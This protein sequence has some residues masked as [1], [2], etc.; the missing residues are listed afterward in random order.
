MDREI[1]LCLARTTVANSGTFKPGHAKLGGRGKGVENK[2]KVLTNAL[3]AKLESNPDLAE[4]IAEAT[5]KQAE[6]GSVAHFKEI[7]DRTEGKVPLRIA[8]EHEGEPIAVSVE[9]QGA[10]TEFFAE[11][12]KK[13]GLAK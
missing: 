12:A 13:L 7:S 6:A 3:K 11:A 2:G 8:G 1:R 9:H 10:G 4:R 5:L